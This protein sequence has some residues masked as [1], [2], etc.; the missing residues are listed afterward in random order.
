MIES[1]I[2]RNYPELGEEGVLALEFALDAIYR[3]LSEVLELVH[4]TYVPYMGEEK[5]PPEKELRTSL[6][7]HY[8]R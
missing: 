2:G 3:N 4:L 5:I 1:I 8:T 6:H 7:L